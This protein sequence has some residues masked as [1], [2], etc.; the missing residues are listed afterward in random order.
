MPPVNPIPIPSEIH[1]ELPLQLLEQQSQFAL[2]QNPTQR[3][4]VQELI[5]TLRKA[6]ALQKRLEE[7]CVRE[8]LAVDHRW[9]LTQSQIDITQVS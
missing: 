8:G 4:I 9:S 1:Y 3:H 7:S 2:S 5:A 6:L